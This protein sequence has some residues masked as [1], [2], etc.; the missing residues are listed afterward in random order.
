MFA[1]TNNEGLFFSGVYMGVAKWSG[2]HYYSYESKRL[3][4]IDTLK[5][6]LYG[7]D[8][9]IVEINGDE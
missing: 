6:K 2:K 7:L 3:A 4:E 1:I 5:Y 9:E 8:A